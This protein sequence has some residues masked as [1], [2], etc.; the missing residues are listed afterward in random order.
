MSDKLDVV[1][2]NIRLFLCKS[3][4]IFRASFALVI[5]LSQVKAC[6]E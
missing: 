2:T 6:D 3:D 5:L 4:E 1:N